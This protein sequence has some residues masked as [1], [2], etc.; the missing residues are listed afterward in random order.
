MLVQDW[1]EL[2]AYQRSWRVN[3]AWLSMI[4]DEMLQTKMF[5]CFLLAFEAAF[6]I[7]PAGEDEECTMKSCCKLWPSTSARAGFPPWIVVH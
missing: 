2:W 5:D 7:G 1:E 6:L 3:V 4:M